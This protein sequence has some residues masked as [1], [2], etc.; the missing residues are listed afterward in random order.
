M[1]EHD[2]VGAGAS[3]DGLV[4]VIAH[5]VLVCETLEVGS[6]ALLDIVEAHGSG[7]FASCLRCG[8]VFRAEV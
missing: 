2:V 1:S 8:R 6:V 5:R 3:I 7:S 4:E